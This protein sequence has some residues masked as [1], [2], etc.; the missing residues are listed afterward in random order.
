MINFLCTSPKPNLTG[1]DA[2]YNEIY[3]LKDYFGGRVTSL[4]P[5]SKPNSSYP[6]L[7]YG[8]HNLFEIK[9]AESDHKINQIFA[10]SLSYLPFIHLLK[11]PIV[12]NVSTGISERGKLFPNGFLKKVSSFVV[13]N[14]RDKNILHENG[15]NNVKIIRSAI[16]TST[17]KKHQLSLNGTLHLMMASAPWETKQFHTKGIHLLLSALQQ[18]KGVHLTFLWRNVLVKDMEQLINQYQVADKITFINE[19]V[20][21]QTLLHKVHGCVLLSNNSSIVKSYPHSLLESLACGKPVITSKEIPMA[22]YINENQCGLILND[23]NHHALIRLIE[24]FKT[25]LQNLTD[26]AFHFNEHDFSIQKMMSEYRLLYHNILATQSR[27]KEVLHQD[28]PSALPQN[29]RIAGG[30][31]TI[32]P[33]NDRS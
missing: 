22:D 5:F 19:N 26:F 11:K 7:L 16:E 25:N 27:S 13:S 33:V 3:K 32:T 9:T 12:Y 20:D 4:Y 28:L 17:F 31:P 15:L 18:L 21:I 14:E 10:P 30:I 1:T 8:A 24:N 29:G 23:F 2:L 6:A